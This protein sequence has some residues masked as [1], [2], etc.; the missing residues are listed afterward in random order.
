MWSCLSGYLTSSLQ[1]IGE[2][3]GVKL[4]SKINEAFSLLKWL[5]ISQLSQLTAPVRHIE[6]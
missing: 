1:E 6:R 5:K 4:V 3:K 2:C